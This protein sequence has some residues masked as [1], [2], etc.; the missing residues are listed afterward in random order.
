MTPTADPN[1][2]ITNQDG[3][4]FN[5]AT[6][7]V[8]LPG[9]KVTRTLN[10]VSIYDGNQYPLSGINFQDNHTYERDVEGQA[11][12]S[13]G[14]TLGPNFGTWQAG[15]QVRDVVKN[16]LDNQPSASALSS[17][18]LLSQF[19][20]NRD[21]SNYYF[22]NY[23]VGPQSQ[24]TDILAFYNANS[25]QFSLTPGGGAGDLRADFHISER[26]YAGYLENTITHGRF[27][28]NAGVRV[29][30]TSDGVQG[31]QPDPTGAINSVYTSNN[32]VYVLP[33][34][35]VQY[36]LDNYT[37]FRAAYSIGIARPN[38]GDLAPFIQFNPG[39][40]DNAAAPLL[41][42]GN[43]ALKATWAENLD[44]LG[45]HYLKGI[46]VI[47][48]GV[49]YKQIFNDIFPSIVQ[50]QYVQP[51]QTQAGPVFEAL[52]VNGGSSH[53][54]GVE[55]SYEQHLTRLPGAL[56]GA[57]YRFNYSY[58]TSVAEVPGRSDHPALVGTAPNNWNVDLTYDKYGLSARMGL[59]H[60]DA[61]I[62]AYQYTDGTPIAGSPTNITLGGPLGPNGDNYYYPHTQV[63]AQVSY[64]VPKGHGAS[65][66]AQ[67]LNLNNE[68]FGFYNGQE[69][70][71]VQREYYSPTYTFGLRWTSNAEHGSVFKQ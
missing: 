8:F 10:N 16:Q 63:D 39:A 53:L 44:L 13:R 59:T 1:V 49:F 58:V 43:P 57:G 34:A 24:A 12:Y 55:A 18:I 21:E 5:T 32:Y 7:D 33:S 69:Q 26:V 4:A 31:Y 2:S 66:V 70:Y 71:P 68:V 6:N 51:G 17:N 56:N 11:D 42:A 35:G 28:Y 14:Y 46:G 9:A 62:S 47:Q 64:L 65:I 37:D 41:N 50:V 52:P 19:P 38:Y 30:S 25:G 29:E 20:S 60:N 54:I 36:N 27:R 67:F 15:F 22:G 23:Q 40:A 45:E 61:Y 48:G 3:V